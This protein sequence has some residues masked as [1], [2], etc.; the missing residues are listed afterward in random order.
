MAFK[1]STFTAAQEWRDLRFQ[2]FE[3]L[4]DHG[5]RM[6]KCSI[7]TTVVAML[8]YFIFL[9]AQSMHDRSRANQQSFNDLV[10]PHEDLR[11]NSYANVFSCF[12][13]DH[14]LECRRPL[15]RQVTSLSA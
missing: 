2:I 10:C 8:S 3:G 11:R 14:E 5:S 7:E 13:F 9:L 6:P 12:E 1:P 15:Y 4:R